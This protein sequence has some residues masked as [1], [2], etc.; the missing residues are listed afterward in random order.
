MIFEQVAGG[1]D[2]NLSY[3]IGE[4]KT[5]KGIII[6]PS[7]RPERILKRAEK[8]HLE[9]AYIINSHSHPDHV[10]GTD[11]IRAKTGAKVVMYKEAGYPFDIG[12][13]EGQIFK[14]DK[15]ELKIIHTPGHSKDSICILVENKLM[16]G[17][18]LFVGK[19]GGTGSDE[20]ARTQYE[21]L[22]KKILTLDEKVEV[23]PGHDYGIKTSSTI[24][25]EKENNPF[26]LQKSFQGFLSLKKNWLEYKRIHGIK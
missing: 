25:Y 23:Y 4:E 1:G 24:G 21:S 18:T 11:H 2:R 16:T 8:H 3:L 19:V 10:A 17:D 7:Y 14:V 13:D 12:V 22:H 20:A 5:R 9:M 15:L 6:D 26:L